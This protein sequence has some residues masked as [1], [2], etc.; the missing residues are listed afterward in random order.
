MITKHLKLV[1][2]LLTLVLLVGCG[3]MMP[4]EISTSEV[5]EGLWDG[6][7]SIYVSNFRLADPRLA[8]VKKIGDCPNQGIVRGDSRGYCVEVRTR[9]PERNCDVVTSSYGIG[10]CPPTY[11]SQSAANNQSLQQ[12][13]SVVAA[14]TAAQNAVLAWGQNMAL[15]AQRESREL[16]SNNS[17]SSE[18]GSAVSTSN[19]EIISETLIADVESVGPPALVAKSR[20]GFYSECFLPKFELNG[21]QEI[22][23]WYYR[24]VADQIACRLEADDDF[25]PGYFNMRADSSQKVSYVGLLSVE[26]TGDLY[27]VCITDPMM[28]MCGFKKSAVKSPDEL[29]FLRGFVER[30]AGMQKFVSIESVTAEQVVFALTERSGGGAGTMSTIA[31]PADGQ[32]HNVAGL[33]ISVIGVDQG[34]VT[35]DVQGAITQ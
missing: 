22:G 16:L 5:P 20:T 28:G 17:P 32:S 21:L 30:P 12:M 9:D 18:L 6:E 14:G 23:S 29:I 10:Y 1:A 2:T 8:Q 35:L 25:L 4:R 33:S 24:I 19:Y 7:G 31:I 26:S 3:S 34:K 15:N 27:D 11:D 13:D